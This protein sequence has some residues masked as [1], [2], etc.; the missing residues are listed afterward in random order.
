MYEYDLNG[1]LTKDSRKGLEYKY[2]RLNLL[3]EVWKDGEMKAQ[4]N[5]LSDGTKVSVRDGSGKNGYDYVGSVVYK[6]V[7][8]C[9]EFDRAVIGDVHFTNEGVRYAL[10]DQL[11][12]VRALIDEDGNVVQQND[13]YPFGAKIV[14]DDYADSDDNRSLFSGKES[15]ELLDLNAYDFGARMYDAS[16]GR[17]NMADPLGEKYVNLSPYNYCVN[18]PLVYVD[19]NGQDYWSTNNPSLIQI[20]MDTLKESTTNISGLGFASFALNSD[21]M[22]LSDSDFAAN[23]YFNDKTNTF[24]LSYGLVINGVPTVIGQSFPNS[25]QL[26]TNRYNGKKFLNILYFNSARANATSGKINV[27]SPEFDILFWYRG[28][29]NTA[30]SKTVVKFGNNPNQEYHAFRHIDKLRLGRE[31]VRLAIEQD[32][33]S[34]I[35]KI[36]P[37]KPFN[38]V[39]IVKGKRLQYTAYKLPDGTINIGRIHEIN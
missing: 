22:H 31:E 28:L 39:I 30:V 24:Y 35:S 4:Y 14:R 10:T 34:H 19:P 13:Y 21:W 18:N 16:L 23:L 9:R 38:K 6:V 25:G 3:E 37:N 1:N 33:R 11:G 17:W 12:S 5:Y 29:V 32:I 26:L 2:N 27:I 15:Q 20:F 36:R 8:G 7:D